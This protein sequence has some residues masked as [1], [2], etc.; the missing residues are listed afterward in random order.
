[1]TRTVATL[2][3]LQRDA[4]R[5]VTPAPGLGI[6]I[7]AYEGRS[8]PNLASSLFTAVTGRTTASFRGVLPPLRSEVDPFDGR[9]AAGPV[10]HLLLDGLGWEPFLQ[11]TTTTGRLGRTWRGR[12][13]PITTVFPS[14]TT[15]AL[16]SASTGAAPSTHGLVGYRQYLPRFGVVADLLRMSPANVAG[17]DLLV[18]REWK[19]EFVSGVPTLFS[20]G[21][22]GSA[23]SR[24]RFEGTGFTR[25]LYDGAT[26]VPYATAAD[27][28]HELTRLLD[29]K[30]PVRT[31]YVYWDELDTIQHL[32]GPERQSLFDLELS[33]VVHLL[34]Y[35][36]RHVRRDTARRTT[37]LVTGDHGQVQAA[38]DRQL[39]VDR[40][41]GVAEEMARP[42]AGDRRAGFFVARP[43]RREA[44][45]EGLGKMLPRGSLVLE[46]ED[47]VAAGLFGPPPHHP[48]LT[49]RLGDF[50]ALVPPP[51]GLTYLPPGTPPTRRHLYGAHGGAHPAELLVPLIAGP[52]GDLAGAGVTGRP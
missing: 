51:W 49:D 3:T 47:A 29:R 44:L 22:A 43:G 37:M 32:R 31:I 1:M 52:L 12:S 6:P 39:R 17:L 2:A 25:V 48:E 40:V 4:K 42:L 16:T 18:Q 46:M 34:S 38:L 19:P 41:R 24:D 30:A 9:R 28:A 27:L 5:L 36:A 10:V 14:T 26:Y 45:R 8:L 33:H 7:P 21:L 23:L 13:R 35:V 15:A 20:R 50:L 11:W